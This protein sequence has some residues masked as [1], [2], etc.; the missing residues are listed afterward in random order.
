MSL[1]RRTM[2]RDEWVTVVGPVT[3][4]FADGAIGPSFHSDWHPINFSFGVPLL[5]IAQGNKSMLANSVFE[6]VFCWR[7]PE[8]TRGNSSNAQWG[9]EVPPWLRTLESIRERACGDW[10]GAV[11]SD[12]DPQGRWPPTV[13]IL[14]YWKLTSWE[15]IFYLV[16]NISVIFHLEAQRYLEGLKEKIFLYYRLLF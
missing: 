9:L 14:N 13:W 11:S 8:L 5:Q 3:S 16:S 12:G 15:F 6:G 4:P 2:V 7:P 1:Q 10:N